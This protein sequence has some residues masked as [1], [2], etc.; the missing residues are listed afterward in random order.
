MAGRRLG[1]GV[2][3]DDEEEDELAMPMVT[4]D[5]LK[6]P[7]SQGKNTTS[8][9]TGS[10]NTPR[11]PRM[12]QQTSVSEAGPPQSP[13]KMQIAVHIRSSPAT[14]FTAT[15]NTRTNKDPPSAL[16]SRLGRT[17]G[18]TS[19]VDTP[20]ILPTSD[21]LASLARS[22]E[23]PSTSTERR[24]RGRPKGWKPGMSS[25]AGPKPKQPKREKAQGKDQGQNQGL[26][27]R[28]RPTRSKP[29]SARERYLQST[30][31][32]TPYKCEWA[33]SN[34]SREKE[35]LICPAELHNLDTLRK[36][37]LLVHGR[38]DPLECQFAS[39]KG[40]DF[41]PKFKTK[42]EFMEHMEKKHFAAYLWRLGE[43]Y[44][45]NGIETL[46]AKAD[47]LPNYLF[48]EHGN[49][50]TPSVADQQV[51]SEAQQ[52]ERKRKLKR[53]QKELNENAPS[54]EEWMQQ[55]LGTDSLSQ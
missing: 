24:K 5:V 32:Y 13:S 21:P 55:L 45:N 40:C 27:K 54:D 7:H 34:D 47:E 11:R 9:A 17:R 19:A 8:A 25:S 37:V 48:D 42:D 52:R 15:S 44:Q 41:P 23:T 43:G 14:S 16:P 4:S 6:P 22:S 39:C 29:P 51:E 33:T 31:D 36:H 28:G 18:R 2:P 26:R 53:F 46:K 35:P 1:A 12:S 30:P 38:M 10:P 3:I 50:V 20:N 49:Q